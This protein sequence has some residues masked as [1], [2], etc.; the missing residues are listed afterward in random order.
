MD[1][2]TTSDLPSRLGRGPVLCLSGLDPSG[3]AGLLRDLWALQRTG[4]RASGLTTCLTVQNRRRCA[5]IV[6]MPP[7]YLSDALACLVEEGWPSA[8]KIGLVANEAE[9]EDILPW[10]REARS[11]HIPIVVDPIRVPSSGGWTLPPEVRALLLEEI[12]PLGVFWTPN[13]PELHWLTGQEDP[14]DASHQL[15]TEGA[16]GLLVKGGH[17]ESAT[18]WVEDAWI[19]KSG[20]HRFRRTRL[21]GP[22]RRGTGCVLS[23]LFAQGLAEGRAPRVAARD[24][25]D[26]LSRLWTELDP[27]IPRH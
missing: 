27:E 14:L 26:R 4:H 25:G 24:A 10:L 20:E 5:S 11:Q 22:P 16:A 23:T 19:E 8:I 13:I 18:V 7:G 12:L 2:E 9:W 15:L 1:S 3:S 6:G 17:D 21:G